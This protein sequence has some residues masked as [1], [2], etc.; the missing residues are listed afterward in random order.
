MALTARLVE[1]ADLT[2][3]DRS[4]MLALME[5]HYAHVLP[6]AFHSDLNEKQWVI[7]VSHAGELCGFSTQMALEAKVNGRPIRA[8]FSGDTIIDR[9]HWGD[10]ALMKLGGE[11]A[12][13]LAEDRQQEDWYWFLIS[14]GYKTY[15]FL[16]VFFRE[17]Y[18]RY[19]APIAPAMQGIID[20]LAAAKFGSQYDAVR[21]VIR[22]SNSQYCLR[23]GVADVT[24][25]RR[26]DP[27]INYF[28]EKNPGHAS[29]E[30][31]CCL[32]PLTRQNFTSAAH[33]ILKASR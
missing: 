20:V 2:P 29:G 14:Q 28:V 13:S 30:E 1:V 5:R 31:L 24:E 9:Q 4:Q 33:R 6:A 23:E 12:L 27:H 17:F 16:P 32:A 18:P 11:L 25:E 21:G 10:T 22:P 15:R 7:Q 26:R 19:D 8:L 3:N